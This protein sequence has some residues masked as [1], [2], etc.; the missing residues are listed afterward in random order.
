[1]LEKELPR[2][3]AVRAKRPTRLPVVMSRAEV[4]QGGAKVAMYVSASVS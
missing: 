4:R 1:V 3:D 2:L